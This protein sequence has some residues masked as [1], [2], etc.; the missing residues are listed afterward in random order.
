MLKGCMTKVDNH[1]LCHIH[2]YPKVSVEASN[3]EYG[4]SNN[5]SNTDA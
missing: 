4:T 3:L 5:L 1:F 2:V